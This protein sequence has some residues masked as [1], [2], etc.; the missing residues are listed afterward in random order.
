MKEENKNDPDKY[1]NCMRVYAKRLTF[2]LCSF[3]L[4]FGLY[5]Y[6]N[7]RNRVEYP[8]VEVPPVSR[9]VNYNKHVS[10]FHR[11]P[12]KVYRTDF[13]LHMLHDLDGDGTWDIRESTRFTTGSYEAHITSDA[14]YRLK[15]IKVVDKIDDIVQE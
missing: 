9:S 7:P 8:P 15:R 11:E 4:A 6:V 10:Q 14:L 5:A 3:T 13:A 12:E 2:Y 1:A